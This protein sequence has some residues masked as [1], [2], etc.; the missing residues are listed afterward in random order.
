MSK[1]RALAL[2]LSFTSALSFSPG[3]DGARAQSRPQPRANG[4]A[5]APAPAS[6]G[7]AALYE[8]AAGYTRRKFDEFKA[9][10]VPFDQKLADKTTQEARDLALRNA[11]TLAARGPLK[12]ADLYHLGLLYQL[13]DRPE[14]ALDAMRRFAAEN[15]NAAP[16]QLQA[17]YRVMTYQA[18]KL[19][20][21]AEAEKALAAYA[22]VEPRRPNELYRLE[23]ALAGLYYKKN[24]FDLAAPHALASFDAA[25]LAFAKADN[26][27][28]RD[29]TLFNAAMLLAD[30]YLKAK[31]RAEAVS[32]LQ[33]LRRLALSLPSA[34]L[35]D[36]AMGQLARAGEDVRASKLAPGDAHAPE[37]VISDWIDQAP[38]KLSDLR[39]RVVLLDFW[40]TWCGP[41]KLTI[42]K[43]NGLHKKY[44][45]RGLVVIGLTRYYGEGE[46]R[47]M[48]PAEELSFVRQYKKKFGVNYPFAVGDGDENS[49]NYGAYSLPTAAL[50]D[51]AGRLRHF[52]VG[53]YDG[54]D[55]EMADAVK[56]LIEEGNTVTSDK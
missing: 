23:N 36:K 55:D 45:D 40:A 50:I 17:A 3:R 9:N 7:G 8:E 51:R 25:K 12:G 41:C 54:S 10:N 43:L 38:V 33:D 15:P 30:S 6:A 11:A 35:Y 1:V 14:G 56:K 4:E 44:K 21:P 52:V 18:V 24:R 49:L 46:G 19:N 26:K 39:G 42:P 47:Q 29:E 53:Y 20:L 5:S 32:A 13:A 48:E 2:A 27:Q 31:R 22:R 28:Q 34:S 37:I 16:E